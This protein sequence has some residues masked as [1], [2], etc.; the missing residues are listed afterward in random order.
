VTDL[1]ISPTVQG[2][3]AARIDRLAPDEKALLQQLAVIGREFPLG[4][5]RQVIAQPEDELSPLLSA[6]QHKEFLYEQ[7][8]L[9]EVEYFF[10]HALTQEVAYNSVLIERRKALHEQ[11]AQ[12]IEQLYHD[13]LE[14]YYSELAHHYRRSRNAEK[15]IEYLQKAGQQSMG[16]S[17]YAEAIAHFTAA[18]ELLNT[19]PQT[20]KREQRE[21]SLQIALGTPLVL[22]KGYSAPEVEATY[23]RARQLCVN[24]GNNLDLLPVLGG[25]WRAYF[26]KGDL[27]MVR[28]LGEQFLRLAQ[29]IPETPFLLVAHVLHGTTLFVLGEAATALAHLEAG[30]NLYD[31]QK[32][33]PFVLS[34]GVDPGMA[35]LSNLADLLWWLGYGDQAREKSDATLKLAREMPRPFNIT[36]SL[37][38]AARRHQF[39]REVQAA[40]TNAEAAITLATEHGFVTR[41]AMATVVRGWALAEDGEYE[42]GIAQIHQGLATFREIGALVNHSYYLALLAEAYRK[43]SRIEDGLEALVNAWRIVERTGERMWEAELYRLKGELTL[44]QEGKEQEIQILQPES[45]ILIP[46][47][48]GEAEA[49]FLKAIN[50]ARQQQAKSLELRATTSLAR[51]WQQQGKR[52]EACDLLAP[53]YHWFTEGFDTKDLQEAKV[54]LGELH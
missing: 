53:V 42:E 31:P 35:V 27:R 9:P 20:R 52:A 24:G 34:F 30:V 46:K 8:A 43:A 1:R 37:D 18:L 49:C 21:L 16:K 12:A 10:K 28:E 50:V 3:L 29:D 39:R 22:T 4:L 36:V 14:E 40:R 38:F 15:A 6:L 11:T 19:L 54:L 2:V 26:T 33:R 41:L 7:P 13:R 51:L 47:S 5:V 23:L 44:Q 25:L 45:Q 48:Q 17:A 32:H